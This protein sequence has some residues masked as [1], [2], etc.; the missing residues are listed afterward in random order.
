MRWVLAFG[1]A[2]SSRAYADTALEARARAEAEKTWLELDLTTRPPA[3]EGL[4]GEHQLTRDAIAVDRRTTL[5]LEL[6]QWSN[7]DGTLPSLDLRGQGFTATARLVRNLGFA[8]LV[9]RGTYAD[10]DTPV[11]TA[12]YDEFG[13]SLLRTVERRGG[14]RVWFG[15]T[16]DRRHWRTDTPPAGE[17]DV[18]QLLFVLGWNF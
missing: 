17:K 4:A 7:T 1:L 14:K 13:I 15:V 18:V 5:L 12:R 6:D 8:T 2:A 16:A 11:G 10:V 9:L 3:L